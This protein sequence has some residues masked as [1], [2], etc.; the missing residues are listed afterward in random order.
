MAEQVQATSDAA[1]PAGATAATGIA[2]LP[3]APPVYPQLTQL[4]V[5]LADAQQAFGTPDAT[6]RLPMILLPTA[7]TR[8]R[9]SVVLI[10]VVALVAGS[11][12]NVALAAR[13][14]A[15]AV[16]LVLIVLGI[17]PAFFVR[18]PEG[19]NA[20]LLAR[21]RFLKT[22]GPGNRQLMPWIQVSHLVTSREI[23]FEIPAYG[24][25]DADGVRVSA[26]L[27]VTFRVVEPEKFVFAISAPDFDQV[28]QASG[29]DAFRRLI[30]TTATDVVLDLS[31]DASRQVAAEMGTALSAYGVRIEKAVLTFVRL[32]DDVMRSLEGRRLAAVQ[33]AEEDEI[34]A[35]RLRRAADEQALEH[36]RVA[37]RRKLFEIEAEN[38]TYRLQQ[39]ER[40]LQEFPAASRWDFEG[41]RL[42]VAR[43]LA[44]NSRAIVQMQAGTDVASSLLTAEA[45][46]ML[47]DPPANGGSGAGRR[48]ARPANG[49]SA[50]GGTA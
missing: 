12:L 19:S 17:V 36:Q 23:P 3:T 18:I 33:L 22:L 32:P 35:L 41:D 37:A 14:G 29:Q 44:T 10:G 11:I 48:R 21:G 46:A 49:S 31:D 38:E 34:Q 5:P 4:T 40:R 9:T 50:G 27:L 24:V 43:A 26:D 7:P 2:V 6:G 8:I 25:P 1:M 47:E 16:G 45:A 15:A 42:N 28:C 20:I 30:R 39:L 13:A